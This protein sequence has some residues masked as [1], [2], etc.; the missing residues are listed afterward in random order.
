MAVDMKTIIADSE[1]LLKAVASISDESFAG[2]RTKFEDKL[3]SA[4]SALA[5]ASQPMFDRARESAMVT[6]NYVHGNPWGVIGAAALA[7]ALIGFLTSRR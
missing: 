6:D 4:K 5:E 7:G 1:D 2:A 3:R